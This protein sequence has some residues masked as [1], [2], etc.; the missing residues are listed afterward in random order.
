M[1]P[2]SIIALCSFGISIITM[3]LMLRGQ[4]HTVTTDYVGQLEKRIETLERELELEK[5]RVKA[6]EDKNTDLLKENIELLRRL[7]KMNGV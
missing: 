7:A 5:N 4:Q 3:I 2:Y 1:N 6:L